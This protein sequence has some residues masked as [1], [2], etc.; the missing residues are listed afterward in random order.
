MNDVPDRCIDYN[1]CSRCGGLQEAGGDD[2]CTCYD[3]N[4]ET[5]K[6]TE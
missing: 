6:H 2:Y 3:D 1:F 5:E 4:E